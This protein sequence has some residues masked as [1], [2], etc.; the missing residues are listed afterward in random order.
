MS[1]IRL[2]ADEHDNDVRVGVL[3]HLAQPAR[4]AL[5]SA[6]LGDVVQQ[7]CAHSAAVVGRSNGPV[8]LL[9]S[10]VPNLGLYIFHGHGIVRKKESI[11]TVQNSPWGFSISFSIGFSVSFHDGHSGQAVPKKKKKKIFIS[12]FFAA[13]SGMMKCTTLVLFC[14]C[15]HGP[16]QHNWEMMMMEQDSAPH[17]RPTR[18]RILSG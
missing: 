17:L 4:D 6:V 16:H 3:A 14:L 2:I 9:S 18:W 11:P 5:V 8:A 10:S 13:G 7:Q 1:Q 15:F 12:F